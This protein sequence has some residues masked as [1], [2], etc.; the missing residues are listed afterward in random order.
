M[1]LTRRKPLSHPLL[2]QIVSRHFSAQDLQIHVLR[3]S[4]CARHGFDWP[5]ILHRVLEVDEHALDTQTM[6]RRLVIVEAHAHDVL[7]V[8]PVRVRVGLAHRTVR[9]QTRPPSVSDRVARI[10][11][12]GGRTGDH[13]AY[14]KHELLW[15]DVMLHNLRSDEWNSLWHLGCVTAAGSGVVVSTMVVRSYIHVE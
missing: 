1:S 4:P 2:H 14:G 5:V 13:I 6:P 8:Q 15:S 12:A 10:P 3:P 9:W 7:A 11:G